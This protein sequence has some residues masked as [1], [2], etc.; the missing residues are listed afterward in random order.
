M[1][2]AKTRI[3]TW[4][5]YDFANTIFSMNVVSLYFP[6]MIKN[7]YGGAD[8]DLSLARSSAMVLVALTM[9]L[10]GTIA[11][12][13]ERRMLP[14]MGFTLL[15]CASTLSL[16]HSSSMLINLMLFALAVFSFQGALVF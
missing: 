16:G 3:F 1:K 12:K 4:S 6:L 11:D 9:P 14:A 2:F 8:I 13:F 7:N 15:C 5:L 10:A